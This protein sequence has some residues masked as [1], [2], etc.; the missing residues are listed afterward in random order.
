MDHKRDKKT[1]EDWKRIPVTINLPPGY[2]KYDFKELKN[3]W[4]IYNNIDPDDRMRDNYKKRHIAFCS[5]CDVRD[6]L[7]DGFT[8]QKIEKIREEPT[9]SYKRIYLS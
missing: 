5:Y 1:R 3:A 6:G 2:S 9:Q 7:P 4:D 8:Y